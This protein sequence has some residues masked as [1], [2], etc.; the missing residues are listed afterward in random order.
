MPQDPSLHINIK[1]TLNFFD[2]KPPWA[3]GNA[4]AIV[5]MLGED[6][7]AAALQHCLESNGSTDV[8]VRSETVGTGRR[9]G[10]RLDRW[11]EADLPCRRKVLFQTEIKSGSAWAIGGKVLAIDA[12][13]E[14]VED[15]KHW[16]WEGQWDTER[17]TLK[18]DNVAKVLVPM[19]PGF[20]TQERVKLPLVIYWAPVSPKPET[21]IQQKRH[22]KGDHLFSIANPS[23]EFPFAVPD[24]W[25]C[26]QQFSELWVFSVSSY[27]RSLEQNEI[28]LN[29]PIAA[30]RIRALNRLA[31]PVDG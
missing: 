23:Y 24:S 21:D 13:R 17:H 26:S 9:R 16:N 10:P 5:A 31:M 22:A 12:P 14:V 30:S 6:L 1:E 25:T 2:E 7:S 18:H 3:S 19:Q 11:I 15:Y 20:D 28:E 27:L 29:M 4:T 8:N